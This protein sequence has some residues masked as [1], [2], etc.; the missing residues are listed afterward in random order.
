[1]MQLL[2]L[3][4]AIGLIKQQYMPFTVAARFRC[5]PAA[6][7]PDPQHQVICH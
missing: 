2:F 1:V 7:L 6:G 4:A 3:P 5:R